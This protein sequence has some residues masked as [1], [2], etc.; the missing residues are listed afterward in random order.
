M[1]RCHFVLSF[2]L[3]FF[4]FSSLVFL[5][6]VLS[7][8]KKRYLNLCTY[9]MWVF[10]SALKTIIQVF[11]LHDAPC[12]VNARRLPDNC[13]VQ[14][15][16][17]TSRLLRLLLC[18]ILQMTQTDFQSCSTLALSGPSQAIHP[19]TAIFPHPHLQKRTEPPCIFIFFYIPESWL[20][21][22]PW[23]L[24]HCIF[25]MLTCKFG[26]VDQWD[27]EII[28]LN[29]ILWCYQARN[30]FQYVCHLWFLRTYHK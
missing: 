10:I 4:F 14:H 23:G 12:C 20:K 16:T 9:K 30:I 24:Q 7:A 26:E 25:I 22:R 3:L 19:L 6:A 2:S 18:T 17:S 28:D 29:N 21:S 13:A 27:L 15:I 5:A 11:L 8:S 1:L